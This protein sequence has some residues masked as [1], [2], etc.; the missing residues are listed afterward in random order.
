MQ[1]HSPVLTLRARS[2]SAIQMRI[3]VQ[4][5][6][7]RDAGAKL[8]SWRDGMWLASEREPRVVMYPN[9]LTEAECVTKAILAPGI[10][11]AS[12]AVF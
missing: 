1:Q 2:S 5:K 11:Y 9:F 6:K 4:A 7:Q 3:R 10:L 12:A 8:P